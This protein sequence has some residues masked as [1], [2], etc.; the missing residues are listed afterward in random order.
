M[1]RLTIGPEEPGNRKAH[2]PE[3]RI[4][5]S[6]TDENMRTVLIAIGLLA[7]AAALT[8]CDE[9]DRLTA[10]PKPQAVTCNCAPPMRGARDVEIERTVRLAP[11]RQHDASRHS[12]RGYSHGSSH[13]WHRSYAERSVDIYGYASRSQ[14]YG[15]HGRGDGEA[16]GGECCG[17]D[18]HAAAAAQSSGV[19]ADGYGRRHRY[20]RSAV[21]HYRWMAR[22]RAKESPERLDPW[23]GYNDDWD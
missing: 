4:T 14:S 1:R 6:G 18:A 20:D 23:H 9:W 19:W 10:P 7:C 22:Q 17:G 13:A 21:R 5:L 3:W 11:P 12:D 16:Y 8:G 2:V 15:A